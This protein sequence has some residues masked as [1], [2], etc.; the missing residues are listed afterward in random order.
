MHERALAKWALMRIARLKRG[1]EPK[2][3]MML[4]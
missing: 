1:G 4:S 3:V 2:L